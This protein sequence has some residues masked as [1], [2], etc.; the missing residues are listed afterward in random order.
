MFDWPQIEVLQRPQRKPYEGGQEPE[1]KHAWLSLRGE[2]A[3]GKLHHKRE[4]IH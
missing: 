3:F 2:P 1:G 4:I